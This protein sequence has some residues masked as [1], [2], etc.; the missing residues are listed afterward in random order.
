LKTGR[1]AE[2]ADF[3]VSA[4]PEKTVFEVS[5]ALFQTRKMGA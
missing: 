1:L 4:A 3:E 2:K 5:V